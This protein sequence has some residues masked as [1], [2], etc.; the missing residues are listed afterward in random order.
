MNPQIMHEGEAMNLF[1]YAQA[2]GAPDVMQEAMDARTRHAL[3]SIF[4][5][6]LI[7]SDVSAARMDVE[8]AGQ[9]ISIPVV[10][11]TSP[12]FDEAEPGVHVAAKEAMNDTN[13]VLIA[14]CRWNPET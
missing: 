10:G 14:S 9:Q 1:D 4:L 11:G 3:N 2:S 6:P 13:S 12:A 8:V 7:M 5:W